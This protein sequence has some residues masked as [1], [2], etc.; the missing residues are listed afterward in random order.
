MPPISAIVHTHNDELRIGR[1]LESLRACDEVIV[2]DHGS[3]D[4]TLAIVREHG[5]RVVD[6]RV[7]PREEAAVQAA[8]P[9][10]LVLQANEVV[11]ELLEAELYELKLQDS[12]PCSSYAVA[13]LEETETGWVKRAAET[14]LV[15]RQYARWQGPLPAPD[16]KAHVLEG[17]LLRL[18]LP[19]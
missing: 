3:Q 4:G 9:W 1:A 10:V 12:L 16:P 17:S 19:G 13:V 8:H 14:R 2:F 5:A 7:I 6:A 18:R 15:P 11:V